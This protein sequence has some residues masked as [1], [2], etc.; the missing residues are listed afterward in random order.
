MRVGLINLDSKLPNIALEKIKMYYGHAEYI[1]PIEAHNYDKVYCSSVFSRTD[2]SYVSDAWICGGTGFDLTTNL[3]KEIDEMKPKIN[4]GFT[5]RG[6]IRNCAFCVVPKKEGKLRVVGDIYDIWDRK[7]KDLCL[8]DNNILGLPSH[9]FMIC[10]QI[11]KEKIRVDFN[12]GLDHRLL[13]D[14]ICK[15]LK[16]IR[17][18]EYHFAFDDI[19]YEKTV[20]EAIKMLNKNGIKRSIWYVLIYNT[21]ESFEDALYRTESVLKPLNQNAFVQRYNYNGN[22]DRKHNE[23]ASWCNQHG[24][25]HKSKFEEFR[26]I[27]GYN[28]N[29]G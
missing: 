19:A 11:K 9:F 25:F 14:D 15:E 16:S 28:F 27:R 20:R 26:K 3:P 12:Q 17:H 23:L 22:W 1:E 21:D 7:N 29:R 18:K 2:K 6:C 4:Y 5:T 13:T 10:E 8:F 24:W